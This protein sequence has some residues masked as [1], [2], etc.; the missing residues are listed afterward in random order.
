MGVEILKKFLWKYL[1]L[2][3]GKSRFDTLGSL[4]LNRQQLQVV[5]I[6]VVEIQ[7]LLNFVLLGQFH[8]L[9]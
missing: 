3:C 2:D 1:K 4:W 8:L 9:Q 5:H 7:V 6:V